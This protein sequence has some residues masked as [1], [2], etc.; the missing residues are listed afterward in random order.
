MT[1]PGPWCISEYSSATPI[2]PFERNSH[3]LLSLIKSLVRVIHNFSSSWQEFVSN[4]IMIIE[5]QRWSLLGG[6]G[7]HALPGNFYILSPQKRNFLDSEHKFPIMSAPKVIVTFQLYLYKL[8]PSMVF[9]MYIPRTQQNELIIMY[10][11]VNQIIFKSINC[12]EK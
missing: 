8:M 7:G 4:Q 6:S 9:Y 12:N 1:L 10:L 5:C 11:C 2:A 3:W